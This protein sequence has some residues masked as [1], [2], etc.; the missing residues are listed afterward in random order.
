MK[1]LKKSLSL[2]IAFA[3]VMALGV[4]AFADDAPAQPEGF[5]SKNFT[6]I[7]PVAAGS[8][9]DII[10]R[11]LTN[12]LDLGKP[13]VVE[14]LAGASQ[15][16]GTAELLNR[17]HDGHTFSTVAFAGLLTQ[18]II[19]PDLTYKTED[20]RPLCAFANPALAV[21][22]VKADSKISSTEDFLEMIKG[23]AD[24]V[25]GVSNVASIGQLSIAELKMGLDSLDH[26]T[27][28]VYNGSAEPIAAL[29]S[30]EIDFIILDDDV[31]RTYVDNGE[32]RVVLSLTSS[33]DRYFPDTEFAGNVV[34]GFVDMP[35]FKIAL[36]P[37]DTPDDIYNWLKFKMDETIVSE[38]YT[39]QLI[40]MGYAPLTADDIMTEEELNN[41]ISTIRDTAIEVMTAVGLI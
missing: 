30:G 29:M 7:V 19:N 32:M 6:C 21:V 39:S 15:S 10:S 24:F 34:E 26:G 27:E 35:G 28:V 13:I 41:Y 16:I 17:D 9:V 40:E 23:E 14:N 33:A 38:A 20:L 25:Y 12:T 8:A 22:A 31:A 37:A 2:I 11:T 5:P 18:P 3:L 4:T 36:V 1:S